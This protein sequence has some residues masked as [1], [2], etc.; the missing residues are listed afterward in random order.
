MLPLAHAIGFFIIWPRIQQKGSGTMKMRVLTPSNRLTSLIG[1]AVCLLALAASERP[2]IV[3]AEEPAQL[4]GDL[5]AAFGQHHA[6]AVHGKGIILEGQ[7]TPTARAKALSEAPLFLQ[8][9]VPVTLRFSDFTGIP[10]IPDPSPNANPRGFA[11]KF[12]LPDGSDMDIVSHSFNGFP[13]A[14]ADEFGELLRDIGA[15]GPD[16]PKPTSLDLFLAAHPIAKTFLTTQKPPPVSYAT[17][18]YYGVNALTFTNAQGKHSVVRYRFVPKAGE[19]YLDQA[20][21]SKQGTNYLIDEI[22]KRVAQK[23]IEFD[24]YAQIATNQDKADDPSIAWPESRKLVKL[25]TIRIDRVV[26]DQGAADK[27]LLFL[28]G[29]F[30]H[31]IAAADPMLAIRSA[32]YP[33]SYGERQ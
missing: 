21:L 19:H 8:P 7:F 13:T 24:W 14:T 6:R 12:H 32:A 28:P 26:A 11:V 29:K 27:A 25:G 2:I 3:H 17:A 16:A 30:P 4:V 5:H 10:D 18:A 15:S 23:P 9:H 31:G 1:T 20:A 22:S 33:V